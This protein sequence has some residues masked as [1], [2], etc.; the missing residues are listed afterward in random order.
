MVLGLS[1]GG[2]KAHRQMGCR[3]PHRE[4]LRRVLALMNAAAAMRQG[5][6]ADVG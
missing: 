4:P 2:A 6:A 3:L 5:A 1:A